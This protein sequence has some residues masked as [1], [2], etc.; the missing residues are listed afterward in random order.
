MRPSSN[1]QPG[2]T[3]FFH[4]PTCPSRFPSQKYLKE[5]I[6][7]HVKGK[8]IK[9]PHPGCNFETV[10]K[11]N[12]KTHGQI[13]DPDRLIVRPVPCSH[14]ACNYRA[15]SVTRLHE[16]IHVRHDPNRTRK[17]FCPKCGESFYKN[18]TLH[19]HINVV[20][21]KNPIS[22][23]DLNSVSPFQKKL[24]Q[25]YFQCELCDY[26]AGHREHLNDHKLT[27]HSDV[28][29]FKCDSPGCNYKTNYARVFKNHVLIHEKDPQK[30]YPVVCRF[31]GCDYRRRSRGELKAHEQVHE[32]SGIQLN[33]DM[34]PD[35]RYP[36]ENSLGFHKWIRHAGKSYECSYSDYA[37]HELRYLAVHVNTSHKG[38]L[39]PQASSS[40]VYEST[41]D[42][43][44][45]IE[46]LLVRNPLEK[47]HR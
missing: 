11:D 38:R 27:V 21:A 20:H 41:R 22:P 12:L 32:E 5:H 10:H 34:C 36:D 13:H 4:C 9:C 8:P 42:Q 46:G 29:K 7:I 19:K 33:C 26:C 16:H 1:H 24:I 28:R 35:K 17:F 43:V 45:N 18:Y 40:S 44:R 47:R 31:P 25:N 3:K 2:T 39:V 6:K 30:K 23:S 14:P 37:V 15:S